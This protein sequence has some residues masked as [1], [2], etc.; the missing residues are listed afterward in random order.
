MRWCLVILL[1]MVLIVAV[2]EPLGT[3]FTYQGEL[4]FQNVPANGAYDFEYTLFDAQTNGAA[5]AGPIQLEN[6]P[7]QGGVFTVELDFGPGLN[8][9]NQLW[10]GI[11][12]RE[13][14][15]QGSFTSLSPRQKLTASPYELSQLNCQ[16]GEIAKIKNGVWT[17]SPDNQTRI[18]KCPCNYQTFNTKDIFLSWGT[19]ICVVTQQ[20]QQEP[21]LYIDY[22]LEVHNSPSNDDPIAQVRMYKEDL[23]F[24]VI[25]FENCR[26][27]WADNEQW[28]GSGLTKPVFDDCLAD[29][30]DLWLAIGD[31]TPCDLTIPDEIWTGQ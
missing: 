22:M 31:G 18:S 9:G 7:V 8:N 4:K 16:E 2:A 12:V 17:C 15:S 6:V 21:Q 29:V 3:G 19:P 11:G 10:L 20:N 5:L 25:G 13:G 30:R 28:I 27:T 26:I 1:S 23:G 24:D 14:V